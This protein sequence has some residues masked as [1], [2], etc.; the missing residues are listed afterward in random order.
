MFSSTPVIRLG[1]GDLTLQRRLGRL[2]AATGWEVVGAAEPFGNSGQVVL[3]VDLA[4]LA[5]SATPAPTPTLVLVEG[6]DEFFDAAVSAGVQAIVDRNDLDSAV[7]AAVRETCQG[8][9]WISP[10]LVLSLLNRINHRRQV[11][12][13]TLAAPAPAPAL[14]SPTLLELTRREAE[15]LR[16]VRK[17]LTNGEIASAIQVEESTVKFHVSN[18]LRKSGARDRTQL[19]AKLLTEA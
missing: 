3:V 7:L 19:L 4:G 10:T 8:H 6:E 13:A 2:F 17:G 11:V 18:I 15:V 5:T 12:G 14:A 1:V 16:W 9:G